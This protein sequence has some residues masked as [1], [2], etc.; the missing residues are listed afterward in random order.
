MS[1]LCSLSVLILVTGLLAE[2]SRADSATGEV[3]PDAVLADLPFLPWHQMNRVVLNLAPEGEKPFRLMLD[4]GATAPFLTPGYAKELGVSIRAARDRP[5]E[6]GTVLGRPLQFWIQTRTSSTLSPSGWEYGLLGGQ[7]LAEYVIEVD[8]PRR[9]VRFIDPD[10]FPV[11]KQVEAPGEAVLPL[12][13][14]ANRPHVQV[15][16]DGKTL[17]VLLDTGAPWTM[18][19]SGESAERVGFRPEV[20]ARASIGGVVGRT[21]AQLVEAHSLSLGPFSFSPAPIEVAPN[22]FF[23]QASSS[24]S[25]IGYEVLRHFVVRLD[26]PHRRLW[27]RRADEEPLAWMSVP[28]TTARRVGVIAGVDDEGVRVQAVLPDTPAERRGLRPGDLIPLS[29]GRDDPEK[30]LLGVLEKVERNAPITVL[31][32]RGDEEWESVALGTEPETAKSP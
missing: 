5:Y 28:W 22:G 14:I 19:L 11:A 8:F 27:L 12:N 17:E 6:R 1:A 16:L 31:R 13:L 21:E 23:N 15:A 9:R 7:F 30:A 20:I 26:Y 32:R 29:G 25:L 4:T 24:D 10:R 2:V 3:P 18:L